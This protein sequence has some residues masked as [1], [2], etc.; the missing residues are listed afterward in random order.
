MKY[1]S[2]LLVCLI[3]GTGNLLAARNTSSI[4]GIVIDKETRNPLAYATLAVRDS[5][6]SVITATTAG[7]DGTFLMDGIP[8]GS[9]QLV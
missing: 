2:T 1:L 9:Y 4:R 5:S 7:S 3:L 8:Y 6:N